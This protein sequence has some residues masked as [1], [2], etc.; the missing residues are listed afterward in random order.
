MF[1]LCIGAHDTVAYAANASDAWIAY[2]AANSVA[3]GVAATGVSFAA[4]AGLAE[5]KYN[6]F[7]SSHVSDL[8]F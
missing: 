7:T 3:A 2:A 4:I 8:T 1:T 6:S 5:V